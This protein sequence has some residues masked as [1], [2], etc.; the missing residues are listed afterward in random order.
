MGQSY[1]RCKLESELE[2]HTWF[3][4]VYGNNPQHL[5]EIWEKMLEMMNTKQEHATDLGHSLTYTISLPVS[6][7]D[8]KAIPTNFNLSSSLA[9]TT[10]L[11]SEATYE[12]VGALLDQLNVDFGHKAHPGDLVPGVLAELEGPD[13]SMETGDTGI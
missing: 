1:T 11:D 12:L 2:L 10:G 7:S 13:K 5:K 9:A 8:L 4:N 3:S 6:I